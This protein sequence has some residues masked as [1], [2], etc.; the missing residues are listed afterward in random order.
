MNDVSQKAEVSKSL[1]LPHAE[2]VLILGSGCGITFTYWPPRAWLPSQGSLGK[3]EQGSE[4]SV[5]PVITEPL[6]QRSPVAWSFF[7]LG[8]EPM[9]FSLP[10]DLV[11]WHSHCSG[12]V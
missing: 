12:L 9:R 5:G 11:Y 10:L 2:L 3:P 1:S 4:H 8:L 6:F 7:F